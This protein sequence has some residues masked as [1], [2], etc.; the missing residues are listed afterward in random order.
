MK[1]DQ[2]GQMI[3]SEQDVFDI[4]MEKDANLYAPMFTGMIVDETVDIELVSPVSPLKNGTKPS[5]LPG[6][7]PKNIRLLTLQLMC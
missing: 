3:F 4:I 5:S 1:T 6:P 2:Y 7:C